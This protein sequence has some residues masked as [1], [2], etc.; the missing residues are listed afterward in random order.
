MSAEA[1]TEN[2]Y[3]GERMSL[4]EAVEALGS[5]RSYVT[6]ELKRQDETAD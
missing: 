1:A 6:S 2:V 4:T 5:L 3:F